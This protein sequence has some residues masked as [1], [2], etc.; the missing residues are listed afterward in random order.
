MREPWQDW[1]D[2]CDHQE[3]VCDSCKCY[4]SD[5]EYAQQYFMDM[6]KMLYGKEPFSAEKLDDVIQELSGHIGIKACDLPSA[7]PTVQVVG[8]IPNVVNVS[9]DDF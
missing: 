2:Y 4:E 5:Q 9:K 3:D 1:D 6:I 7:Y 8:T